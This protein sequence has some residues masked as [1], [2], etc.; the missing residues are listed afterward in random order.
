MATTVEAIIGLVDLEGGDAAV[1]AVLTRLGLTNQALEAVTF[2]VLSR[3]CDQS[4]SQLTC[5]YRLLHWA[6]RHP[7][8]RDAQGFG[9]EWS[10]WP[11]VPAS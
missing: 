2:T 10:P 9:W 11:H 4:P 8:E 5:S 3:L 6:T 1:E 7:L